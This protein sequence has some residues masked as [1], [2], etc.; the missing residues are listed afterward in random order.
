[1]CNYFESGPMDQILCKKFYGGKEQ[2]GQFWVEGP[3]RN[4]CVK[5]FEFGNAVQD[6]MLSE[7]FYYF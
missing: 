4:I 2:F 5:L 3:M 1:M 7:R 6:E